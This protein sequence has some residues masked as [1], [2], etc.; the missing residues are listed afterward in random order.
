VRRRSGIPKKLKQGI[1]AACIAAAGFF[2]WSVEHRAD[3]EICLV[4]PGLISP[5]GVAAL[6][7]EADKNGMLGSWS[8]TGHQYAFHTDG[9]YTRALVGVDVRWWAFLG[10]A[11][12]RS[13]VQRVSAVSR[14]LGSTKGIVT[15]EVMDGGTVPASSIVVPA[16]GGRPS[17]TLFFAPFG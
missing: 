12:R 11:D 9:N 6:V 14:D 17:M 8:A 4:L 15:S 2:A 10:D 5:A 3:L 13:V 1:A 7:A 16:R